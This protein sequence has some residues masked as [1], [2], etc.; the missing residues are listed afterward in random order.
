M[1]PRGRRGR[2]ALLLG[3]LPL[4]LALLMLS[5]SPALADP[6]LGD[7]NP[8]AGSYTI[9][10][11]TLTLTGPGT[12][13]VGQDDSGIATFTFGTVN[14]PTGATISASGDLPLE[15]VANSSFTLAGTISGDGVS[16]TEVTATG[17]G[18]AGGPGGGNGGPGGLNPG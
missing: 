13:F 2:L 16:A 4:G 10:T 11:T 9:N 5:A 7:W 14:I 1:T 12:S 6:S 8:A 18:S 15:L 3:A 17:A